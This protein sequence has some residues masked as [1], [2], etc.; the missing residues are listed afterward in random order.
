MRR[1][2]WKDPPVLFVGLSLIAVAGFTIAH[3]A[4]RRRHVV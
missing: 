1:L 3:I 4:A 2:S